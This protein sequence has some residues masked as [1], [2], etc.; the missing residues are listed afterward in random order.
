MR[1]VFDGFVLYNGRTRKFK[2]NKIQ[3][4]EL[5]MTVRYQENKEDDVTTG[6]KR[7]EIYMVHEKNK[8]K[9]QKDKRRTRTNVRPTIT[10]HILAANKSSRNLSAI[11]EVSEELSMG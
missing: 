1:N 4:I 3:N 8:S 10:G 9:N 11:E 5:P 2:K 6:N 7:G